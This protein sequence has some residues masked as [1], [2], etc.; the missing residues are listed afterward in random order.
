MIKETLSLLGKIDLA[1]PGDVIAM[2]DGDALEVNIIRDGER[3]TLLNLAHFD[4]DDEGARVPVEPI[5]IQITI[6]RA[7]ES[8]EVERRPAK[9]K[10]AAS[11]KPR[12]R[13]R[14]AAEK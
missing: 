8:R 13:G 14:P 1:S 2:H 7:G 3:M 10:P 4:I 12:R 6:E 11:K 9:L 5:G